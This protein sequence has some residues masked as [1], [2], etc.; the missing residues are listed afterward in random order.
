MRRSSCAITR[1]ITRA[2]SALVRDSGALL[3]RC[4]ALQPLS[5]Y[6]PSERGGVWEVGNETFIMIKLRDEDLDGNQ[7]EAY[8]CMKLLTTEIG[9]RFFNSVVAQTG[10]DFRTGL[11]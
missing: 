11:I 10:G 1:A 3:P 2:L 6:S 7:F 9:H 5:L 4:K 8:Y